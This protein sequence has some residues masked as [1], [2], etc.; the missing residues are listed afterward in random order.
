MVTQHADD[1]TRSETRVLAALA[2]W[3]YGMRSFQ[4]LLTR[5]G[6]PRIR[7]HDLRQTCATLL[8]RKRVN[9]KIVSELLGDT[10]V[11]FTLATYGHVQAEMRQPARDA[12]K[13]LFGKVLRCRASGCWQ[14][15]WPIR[16]LAFDQSTDR[17]RDVVEHCINR[18][19]HRRD[20]PRRS[21]PFARQ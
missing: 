6:L 9:P 21:P 15:M 16:S 5:A 17:S 8:L 19:N 12:M 20:S 13:R 3:P 4:P 10:S 7:F 1:L 2:R 11:A 14:A 18:F